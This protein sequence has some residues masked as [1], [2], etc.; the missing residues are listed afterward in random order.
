M[1]I[2]FSLRNNTH[3]QLFRDNTRTKIFELSAFS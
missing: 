1:L 2:G 3:I